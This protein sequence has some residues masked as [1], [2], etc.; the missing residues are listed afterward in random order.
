[1]T[2][3]QDGQMLE[4]GDVSQGCTRDSDR[5]AAAE[6]EAVV[7]LRGDRLLR[8]I[9]NATTILRPSERSSESSSKVKNN[10]TLY[11]LQAN[12]KCEQQ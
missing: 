3:V 5:I 6:G 1:M 7:G 8:A 11:R 4:E 12:R 2:D 9:T 10:E